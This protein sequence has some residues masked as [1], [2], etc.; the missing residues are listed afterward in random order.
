MDPEAA[1]R[2]AQMPRVLES[3]VKPDPSLPPQTVIVE[4]IDG[5]TERPMPGVE[6][7]L[8]ITERSVAKG[9][10]KSQRSAKTDAVG[11]VTFEKLEMPQATEFQATIV[12][13]GATFTSPPFQLAQAKAM[14][15]TVYV[16]PVVRSSRE[17]AVVIRGFAYAEILDEMVQVSQHYRVFNIGA[18]AWQ[19][20]G[21]KIQLPKGA[22]AFKAQPGDLLWTSS[23]DGATLRGTVTPGQHDASFRFQIPWNGERDVSF[24]LGIL[25]QV[26]SFRLASDAPTGL[27]LSAEGF[28]DAEAMPNNSGQRMLVVEKALQRPDFAFRSIKVRLANM[29]VRPVGRW[30]AVGFALVAVV[31]GLYAARQLRAAKP[32]GGGL[33]EDERLELEEAKVRLLDEIASLDRAHR[34]GEVGPKT[35]ERLRRGLTDALAHLLAQLENAEAGGAAPYRARAERGPGRKRRAEPE[36]EPVE[37]S[38]TLGE[39]PG[40]NPGE[41]AWGQLG[42]PSWGALSHFYPPVPPPPFTQGCGL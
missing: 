34:S 7:A 11:S 2:Q 21:I 23:E 33:T 18:T 14:R 39:S 5:S 28:S 30:Y 29:P 6:V 37:L 26:Q 42:P 20:E 10:S 36:A 31:G 38:P 41:H 25:P 9:D 32:K 24:E 27:Q 15:A 17:A 40:G 19:A 35:Y 3:K 4:V 22:K 13:D 12:R 8:A 16:F 1:A